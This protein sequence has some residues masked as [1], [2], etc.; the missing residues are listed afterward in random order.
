MIGD[1]LQKRPAKLRYADPEEVMAGKCASCGAVVR[2]LRRD[3]EYKKGFGVWADLL[4][5]ECPQ[6]KACVFV[7]PTAEFSNV[8]KEE[9]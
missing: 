2:C 7:M 5:T 1:Q 9:S 8:I 4:A 6:C 3:A